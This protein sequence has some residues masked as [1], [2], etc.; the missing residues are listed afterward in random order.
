MTINQIFENTTAGCVST[1]DV[2]GFRG[3]LFSGEKTRKRKIEKVQ[4]IRY[5]RPNRWNIR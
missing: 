3:R 2:G 5:H 1:G 4:I